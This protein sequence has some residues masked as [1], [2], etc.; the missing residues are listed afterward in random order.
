MDEDGRLSIRRSFDIVA[1]EVSVVSG[2][3]ADPLLA[4]LTQGVLD[5][6]AE[7]ILAGPGG[8]ADGAAELF[9]IT[10]AED[11]DWV[12]LRGPGDSQLDQLSLS[13]DVRARIERN[14]ADGYIAIS[15]RSAESLEGRSVAWW[16]VDP[17]TGQTLG[18]DQRGH[19]AAVEYEMSL[20]REIGFIVSLFGA[21]FYGGYMGCRSLSPTS[22]QRVCVACGI[23]AGLALATFVLSVPITAPLIF[24]GSA[25]TI[26][27]R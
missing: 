10:D 23:L 20:P 22:T 25:G 7:A 12:A 27:G 24:A 8:C 15:P 18:I 17:R 1:N 21:G 19:G 14:L 6:N 16:R 13:A 9:A 4:P 11:I 5:S 26:C 2:A 3:D